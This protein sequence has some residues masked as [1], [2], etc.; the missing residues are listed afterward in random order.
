MTKVV[1]QELVGELARDLVGAIA[2]EELPLFTAMSKA[3]FADPTRVQMNQG[4]D[5]LAF[6]VAEAAALLSPVLLAAATHT[7]NYA[8]EQLGRNVAAASVDWL[9]EQLRHLFHRQESGVSLDTR[10]IAQVRAIT[11]ET[12]RKFRV[13][14]AKATEIADAVTARFAPTS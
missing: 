10:Q 7:L 14:K 11:F 9:R 8:G 2:P 13:P 1:D 6:G 12:A 3:W 4:D 5:V